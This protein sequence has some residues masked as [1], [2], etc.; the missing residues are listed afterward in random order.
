MEK[1]VK[2]F[3]IMLFGFCTNAKAAEQSVKILSP[4]E[5]V[6][7]KSLKFGQDLLKSLNQETHFKFVFPEGDDLIPLPAVARQFLKGPHGV[8]TLKKSYVPQD[9]EGSAKLL[10]Q[11]VKGY[12]IHLMPKDED[13]FRVSKMVVQ[14][15]ETNPL[16]QELVGNIKIKAITTEY[17]KLK[18]EKAIREM[19]E[20]QKKDWRE[21]DYYDLPRIII[22][23]RGGREAAQKALNEIYRI[24]KNVEGMNRGPGF[25]QRVTSLIYFAQGNRE[26]K[27]RY[28]WQLFEPRLIYYRADVTGTVE[29]YHLTIPVG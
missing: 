4:L 16:L 17:E 3:F 23:V 19:T 22:Y 13:L 25:N 2:L 1:I 8:S 27:T 24:F 7:E 18:K 26:D 21:T 29:D 12:K 14:E 9:K 6:K 5:A 10:K 20:E 11:A 15:L 28:Y